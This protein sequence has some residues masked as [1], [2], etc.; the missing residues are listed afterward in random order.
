[1]HKAD[2]LFQ[3]STIIIERQLGELDPVAIFNEF[4]VS[5]D[6]L[7]PHFP[8]LWLNHS[9]HIPTCSWFISLHKVFP[10]DNVA[11]HSLHSGGATAL[12]IAG[13]PLDHIQM[14]G[15]WLSDA[16]LIY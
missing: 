5:C 2:H 9:S 1:M 7:F 11:S 12:T 10:N 8:E 4:L 15:C 16:F 13:T 3:G 6:C 14:I